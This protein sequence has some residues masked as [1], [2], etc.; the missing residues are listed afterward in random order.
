MSKLAVL[1][2]GTN[3]IH[4]VLA[5]VE[6]DFSYK[7]LDRFKDVTRL[8]DGT[9]K[10]HR[11]PEAA[12]RRGLEV[13][14]TQVTLARNKGYKRIKA[15]ATSAV[16]EAQNGGEFLKAIAKA[17]GLTVRVVTGQEE[18]RLIYLGVR[19]SMELS[20]EPVLIVDIG[21]GSVELIA[22]KRDTMLQGQSLKLG[23]IR[24]KDLYLDR[25]P[26]TEGMV[27]AAQQIIAAEI[28]GAMQRFKP[29]E[30][31][32]MI[33]ASGMIGNLAEIA[34]LRRTGKQIPQLNLATMARKEIEELEAVLRQS[35]VKERLAI[36]GLDPKRADTLL[37]ATMVLRILM[38]QA[39]HETLT[40]SDKAI[41]EGIIY[42]FIQRHQEGIR[43]EQE[44]PNVRRR[45]VLY[46]AQRCQYP[47][48]HSHHVAKLALQLFDQTA[49][50]HRLGEREREWLEYAALLHDIGYL[51]NSQQHHKHAHYLITQSEIDGLA[52]EEI[53]IVANIARYHRRALPKL[54]HGPFEALSLKNRRIVQKLAALLR[55]ADGLDRSQFTVVQN[56]KVRLGRTVRVAL[57][58][59]SDPEL[60]I[61]A[62]KVRADLFERVFRRGIEFTT[63]PHQGDSA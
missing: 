14:K 20:D 30:F 61:W 13:I 17:T 21:G 24:L 60:E 58:T 5:E 9:F 26:P 10:T 35:T 63:R 31:G 52:A 42:D 44:I 38:Q 34:H 43:A 18:A 2:I 7:I 15:V 59:T 11:L 32:R 55:I 46:L 49:V 56:L 28:A 37:P 3:S 27:G 29:L 39:G 62:A 22:G 48:A 47:K 8:G 51:I 50:L 45:N 36:P 53:E 1:D 54:K 23:A 57:T 41:R 12:M 16:R 19:H 4:M 33:G 6:S 40:V 25:S